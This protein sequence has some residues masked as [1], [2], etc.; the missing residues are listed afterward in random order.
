MKQK[1]LRKDAHSRDVK[2]SHT[3][4]RSAREC[5]K[6]HFFV[7]SYESS[8]FII[9]NSSFIYIKIPGYVL[10]VCETNVKI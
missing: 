4:T 10:T 7:I 5:A 8:D 3:R 1:M 6:A 9:I 2:M